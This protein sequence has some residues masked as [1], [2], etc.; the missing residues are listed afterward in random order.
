MKTMKFFFDVCI[1]VFRIKSPL[2]DKVETQVCSNY[3]DCSSECKRDH[4]VRASLPV[5]DPSTMS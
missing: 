2:G 1:E 5:C 3:P 4:K